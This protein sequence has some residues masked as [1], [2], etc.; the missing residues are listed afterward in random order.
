MRITPNRRSKKRFCICKAKFD[1]ALREAEFDSALREAEFDSALHE[2]NFVSALHEFTGYFRATSSAVIISPLLHCQQGPA[3]DGQIV[4]NERRA[5][6]CP[7]ND[8][9]RSHTRCMLCIVVKL[10]VICICNRLQ[11]AAPSIMAR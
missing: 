4:H 9:F 11:L 5:I 6:L 10:C 8:H 2:A 7:T 1:S 3:S